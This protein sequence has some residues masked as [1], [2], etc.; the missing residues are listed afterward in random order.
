[1]SKSGGAIAAW[2]AGHARPGE[3]LVTWVVLGY[4]KPP[5]QAGRNPMDELLALS[6]LSERDQL[7]RGEQQGFAA[8]T[9]RRVLVGSRG[10]VFGFKPKNL[11]L[12]EPIDTFHLQWFDQRQ[13]VANERH[14][15]FRFGDT[16]YV[17]SS[18]MV[19]ER[20]NADAFIAALGARA[21]NVPHPGSTT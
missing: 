21:V 12:D 8:I 16:R 19:H 17:R 5:D 15:L 20:T 10:G 14:L 4:A 18:A 9:D 1:M 11:L 6:G 13:M 7:L 2:F 3:Q